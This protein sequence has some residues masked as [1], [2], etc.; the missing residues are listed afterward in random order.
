MNIYHDRCTDMYHNLINIGDWV[1][2]TARTYWCVGHII[3]FE[4][5]D[6]V[7]IE[8]PHNQLVNGF[9]EITAN[10]CEVEKL[11]EDEVERNNIVML[12]TFEYAG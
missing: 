7:R 4:G 10:W 3:Y 1:L 12:R 9:S 2:C 5:Y 8:L 6:G 11:P